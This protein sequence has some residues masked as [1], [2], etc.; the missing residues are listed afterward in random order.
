MKK[1]AIVY[2]LIALILQY[3]TIIIA[4]QPKNVIY[5]TLDGLRWQDLYE[6]KQY[7][8]TLWK[9]HAET[10]HFY[11]KPGSNKYFEVASVPISQPS[12]TSQMTGKV[13]SCFDNKC[14]R[15]SQETV[16]EFIKLKLKLKRENVAVFSSWKQINLVAEHTAGTIVSNNSQA[17]M[18][19]PITGK[20]DSTMLRL[21]QQQTEPTP[22]EGYRYDRYTYQQAIHY[23]KKYQPKLLWIGLFD[24]DSEA[25]LNNKPGYDKALRYFDYAIDNLIETL[26]EMGIYQD[27]TIIITTDHGRGD[28]KNWI[29]HGPSYPESK[30]TWAISFN[31]EIVPDGQN[32]K[33]TY[34]S[35][36]SIRKTIEKIMLS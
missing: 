5:V 23:L 22:Y 27:T 4:A 3:S 17:A 15:I 12:Y 9:K 28:G 18:T 7:F 34:Y 10:A 2:C 25:H 33:G 16:L 14:S 1:M 31:T 19:D 36:K 6:T 24:A 35:T 13:L 29:T 20:V 30:K 21:N 8:P 11:G 32:E 26:K